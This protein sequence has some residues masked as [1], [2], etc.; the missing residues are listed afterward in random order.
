MKKI[1][2]LFVLAVLA[3]T[4]SACSN[5]NDGQENGTAT[6]VISLKGSNPGSRAAGTPVL[7]EEN[8]VHE[9]MVYIFNAN[10]NLL[11]RAVASTANPTAV[12]T[13]LRP[14]Q[15]RIVVL[16]NF[17]GSYPTIGVGDSYSILADASLEMTDLPAN[18]ATNGLPISGET[19]VSLTSGSNSESISVSRMVAR[20]ELGTVTIVDPAPGS[21][22]VSIDAVYMMKARSSALATAAASDFYLMDPDAEYWGGMTDAGLVTGTAVPYYNEA[23]SPALSGA[24]SSGE[25]NVYFYVFPN[26]G[27]VNPTQITLVSN[28]GGTTRYF[29]VQINDGWAGRDVGNMDGTFIKRNHVYVLNITLQHH[30]AGTTSPE[31]T[32]ADMVLELTVADWAMTIN[33]TVVW[34]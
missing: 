15:K 5:D 27:T 8:A 31:D 10:T 4:F 19:T 7:T 16:A 26:D 20:V 9:F 2:S 18:I 23:I 21:T 12:I 22:G 6:L 24:A 34:Q 28:A 11:E 17:N 1:L 30:D 33:Q 29:P 14:G 3:T 25:S 13:G 32:P